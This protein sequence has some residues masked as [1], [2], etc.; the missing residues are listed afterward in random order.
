LRLVLPSQDDAGTAL[1]VDP[2]KPIH[3][4]QRNPG[5]IKPI[6]VTDV[7]DSAVAQVNIFTGDAKITR[8]RKTAT[9][10]YRLI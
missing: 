8:C 1:D 5:C 3:L 2:G 7:L 9:Q 6:R 10:T 4:E